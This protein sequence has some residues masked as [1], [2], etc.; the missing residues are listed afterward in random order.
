MGF[1]H[2]YFV[3]APVGVALPEPPRELRTARL[4]GP[5]EGG[6]LCLDSAR[7]HDLDL[8]FAR[9]LSAVDG[10]H[11]VLAFAD[12]TSAS[13]VHCERFERGSSLELDVSAA[14][15][16]GFDPREALG[17]EIRIYPDPIRPF[18]LVAFALSV[19]ASLLPRWAGWNAT[20]WVGAGFLLGWFGGSL[21]LRHQRKAVTMG[22]GLLIALGL[23]M[24][25]GFTALSFE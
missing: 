15:R 5:L 14:E 22:G 3:Q 4:C 19:A 25:T 20:P 2:R 24:L 11:E 17:P 21:W 13:S 16:L 12:Q 9:R 23:A 8:D 1:I 10:V 6:W 7:V 18:W